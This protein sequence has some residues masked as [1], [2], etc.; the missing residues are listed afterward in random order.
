[1]KASP[2]MADPPTP[3][4]APATGER[5]LDWLDAAFAQLRTSDWRPLIVQPPLDV[6]DCVL[7]ECFFAVLKHTRA[8]ALPPASAGWLAGLVEQARLWGRRRRAWREDRRVWSLS[9]PAA[10]VPILFWP[11]EPTHVQTHLPVAA[12]I[13]AAGGRAAF[14]ASNPKVLHLVRQAGRECVYLPAIWPQVLLDARREGQR[15]GRRLRSLP[16]DV[17]DL[18]QLPRLEH[19][20]GL[21][22][23]IQLLV[24]KNLVHV[25]ETAAHTRECV[26]QLG[27]QVLVVGND[28][29]VEGRSSC[30]MARARGLPTVALMHGTVSGSALQGRHVTDR[31]L[32]YGDSARRELVRLGTAAESIRVVGAP[33]LDHHPKQSGAIDPRIVHQLG[34]RADRPYVLIATS[35]PGNSVSHDHHHRQIEAFFRLSQELP[36]VQ[37]VAKLHRKDQM[38][39]YERIAPSVAGARLHV[40]GYGA[41]GYPVDIFSWLQG[42][43]LLITGAS[44]VAVEAML[45]D[46]PVVTFDL[47]HELKAVDFIQQGA[48][49]HA[50]STSE[51]RD[52]VVALTGTGVS[53]TAAKQRA[54][55]Y[56]RDVFLAIDGHSAE[57]CAAEI[58]QLAERALN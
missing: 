8:A 17:I 6:L 46:V 34:L 41:E 53:P 32:V 28:I 23:V 47:A 51:L 42:C 15:T 39:Y 11:R 52:A 21:C 38:A 48:T 58:M 30:Q 26:E 12:A 16:S 45:F 10:R 43:N 4:A 57:R 29:T 7:A 44:T 9:A 31:Y 14:V 56:L 37:F 2:G 35:G 33:Y 5:L 25:Q 18:K 27:A 19:A 49:T 50:T 13:A 40:V 54:D 20:A 55:A 1:M 3:E 36:E 24:A 22:R